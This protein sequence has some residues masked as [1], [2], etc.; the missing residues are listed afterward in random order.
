MARTDTLTNYL[1]DVATAIKTKKGDNTPIQA[2]NFDTEI[3]NLPSGGGEP[4]WEQIGYEET[5]QTLLETFDYS[6]NIYDNWDNTRTDLSRMF[7][8]N[9]TL[10]Y[11][12]KITATNITTCTNMFQNCKKIK[13]V[14]YLSISGSGYS[15]E[16]GSIFYNCTDLK[17]IGTISLGSTDSCYVY[18]S[19]NGCTSL[20]SIDNII[21]TNV[22]NITNLFYSCRKLKNIPVIDM[23]S[24]R[25]RNVHQNAFFDCGSLT[26]QSIDN[27]LQSLITSSLTGNKTL[28]YMG[29]TSATQPASIIQA[30]PHY[31]DFIN[32][33]WSIGY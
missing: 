13:E 4:N 23:S 24:V 15:L 10:E 30:L 29:F 16:Y 26:N 27:I 32:A 3:I 2:S 19:F 25:G 1:T 9:N 17:Y 14:P 33:G 22:R 20:E 31:Q 21:L 8:N 12:P 18:D 7:Y 5:P 6:K 11:V 28:A